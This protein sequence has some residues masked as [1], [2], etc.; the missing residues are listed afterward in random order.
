MDNYGERN[1]EKCDGSKLPK[2]KAWMAN[3]KEN[4]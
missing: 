2:A 1:K 3:K 4:I